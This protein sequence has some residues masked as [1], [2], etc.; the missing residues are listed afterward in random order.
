MARHLFFAITLIGTGGL[1]NL[2]AE[3][4]GI[5]WRCEDN[6]STCLGRCADPAGG[7]GDWHGHQNKCLF[8]C[9][10]RLVRCVTRATTRH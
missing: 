2:P 10:R 4:A 6:N 3:A 1:L 7:A 5:S 8:S 9:D